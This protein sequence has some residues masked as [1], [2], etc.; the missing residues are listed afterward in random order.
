MAYTTPSKVYAKLQIPSSA[1][2]NGDT[3]IEQFIAWADALIDDRTGKTWNTPSEFTNYFDTRESDYYKD[4][5]DEGG[6]VIG[7]KPFLDDK[8][9]FRLKP[10]PV[11]KI[12][13]IWV[14]N[15]DADI[16]ACYSYDDSSS[17]Y[18]DNTT[19]ANSVRGTPFYAFAETVAVGDCLYI[20]LSDIFLGITINLSVSGA[21]GVCAW[22]YYNGS[23]WTTLSV[24]EDTSGADDLNASGKITWSLPADWVETEVNGVSLYWIK[25]E[26]TTKHTT[27]PKVLSIVP[28][29]DSVI[30]DFISV[31]EVDWDSN[32]RLVLRNDMLKDEFR[33]LRVNFMAGANSVPTLVEELSTVLAGIKAL[34]ALLSASYDDITAG[35]KGNESWTM[36]EPYTNLSAG[37]KQLE[38]EANIL[39]KRLGYDTFIIVT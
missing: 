17:S 37:I 25:I 35:R 19:E 34:K 6:I 20:G 14:L 31:Y 28:D 3:D 8:Q 24:T 26:V 32:G 5:E 36:G 38:A 30:S 23:S 39:W 11:T 2:V 13:D 9:V 15:R 4:W 12:K 21:D 1:F 18:S 16:D 33:H 10:T 22:K 29:K 7:T 27:S